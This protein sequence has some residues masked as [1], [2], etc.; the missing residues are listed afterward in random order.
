MSVP[1]HQID[2]DPEDDD[3]DR[4]QEAYYDLTEDELYA[5]E[6]EASLARAYQEGLLDP[7]VPADGD[8]YDGD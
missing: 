6:E 4:A 5:L 2:P 3:F 8:E 1:N 7:V